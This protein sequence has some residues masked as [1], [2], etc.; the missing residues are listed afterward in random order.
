MGGTKQLPKPTEADDHGTPSAGI[1]AAAK[2]E[3][4][5]VG[6]AFNAKVAGLRIMSEGVMKASDEADGL[7]HTNQD[8]SIYSCGYGPPTQGKKIIAPSY[9]TK[10]A[11]VD[12]VTQG[13]G[14]K[15]SIFVF[16]GGNYHKMGDSCNYD[17][18]VNR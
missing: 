17:G 14:T 1:I 13:R 12:G 8:V 11:L 6:I 16:A 2:N 4:C 7:T 5:G 10:K 15:G 9:V 3:V 18:W